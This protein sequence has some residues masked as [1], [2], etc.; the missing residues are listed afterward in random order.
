MAVAAVSVSVQTSITV[1]G[2]LSGGATGATGATGPT[3][4]TGSTGPTGVDGVTGHTGPTGYTG[5]TGLT[6]PTGDTG[7]TGFGGAIGPVGSQYFATCYKIIQGSTTVN[8]NAGL[9][10]LDN[11]TTVPASD[12]GINAF[13][14]QC[15]YGGI[16]ESSFTG[17]RFFL[18]ITNSWQL[19]LINLTIVFHEKPS[20]GVLRIQLN[21]PNISGRLIGE[22]IYS[23]NFTYVSDTVNKQD[24]F[25]YHR[26]S[27]QRWFFPI[28]QE[29]QL[30]WEVAYDCPASVAAA[31]P[32]LTI[33]GSVQNNGSPSGTSWQ[34]TRLL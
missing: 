19:W 4:H 22:I 18:P 31:V 11:F 26:I 25:N 27:L 34:M 8:A 17:R 30:Y 12:P 5:F 3:G 20:E 7:P 13:Y 16:P 15:V 28:S 1:S 10:D 14:N 23:S 33:V 24:F 21:Y 32:F 6:G 2:L 29:S 9:Q